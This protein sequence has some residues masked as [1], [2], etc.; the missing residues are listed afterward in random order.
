MS[1]KQERLKALKREIDQLEAEE[2]NEANGDGLARL[3]E[4]VS[5]TGYFTDGR[6]FYLLGKGEISQ[7]GSNSSVWTIPSEGYVFSRMLSNFGVSMTGEC[8]HL[9]GNLDGW[10]PITKERFEQAARDYNTIKD[11]VKEAM[12]P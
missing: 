5:E 4:I 7:T 8:L 3:K 1:E 2:R 11:L 6:G 9:M 10:A 12:M